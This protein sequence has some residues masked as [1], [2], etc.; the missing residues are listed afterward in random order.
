M[1][2][3]RIRKQA[4]PV[5]NILCFWSV[6]IGNFKVEFLQIL[7]FEN[8]SKRKIE[9]GPCTS[10]TSKSNGVTKSGEIKRKLFS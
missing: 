7:Y 8:G 3:L 1:S 9:S 6:Q 10:I 5:L 2:C 4:A